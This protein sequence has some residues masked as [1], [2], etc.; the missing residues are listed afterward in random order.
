MPFGVPM[1]WSV[2]SN[3]STNCYFCTV[4]PIQNG[5]S[6]KKKSTLVYPN[7]PSAIWPVP[8]CDGL[9]VSEPPDNFAVY[10][11]DEDSVS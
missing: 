4:F 6:T 3:H 9:P 7:I 5:M 1:V 10:S 11:N 8:Q 2:P